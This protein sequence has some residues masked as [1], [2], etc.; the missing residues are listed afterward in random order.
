MIIKKTL[1]AALAL[2]FI[3]VTG[4]KKSGADQE[5]ILKG[6]TTIV[7]DE[8][9]LPI[10]ED[11]VAVFE[12]KYN[13]KI[14]LISLSESECINS[15][16]SGKEKIV[17]LTRKLN[18]QEE[19]IIYQNKI[20]PRQTQFA[21]DGIAFICNKNNKDSLI[22]I[23]ELTDFLHQ[24]PS[25]IKKLVFDNPNSST[26]RYLKNKAGLNEM[27]QKNIFSFNTNNQV[28]KY[29]SENEN[30]IGV[31]GI[32]WIM[33]PNPD[34]EKYLNNI[35]TLKVKDVN[36]TDYFY[37]SQDNIAGTDYPLARDLYIINCQ[38]GKGLGMGFA[39]FMAG[40]IGQR[41]VLKSGLVPKT[42]PGRKIQVKN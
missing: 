17:I 41:I 29:V 14:K 42:T 5:T 26:V 6:T 20:T 34:T 36:K 28:I 40:E 22:S 11:Q 4:C 1:I 3:A 23:A 31:I 7:V 8:S 15:I 37:P 32:N 16:T 33:Q 2:L 39:S 12:S 10:V 30:M 21:T 25:K 9:I 18:K 13:A 38:G 24:K 19:K 27:P 35:T